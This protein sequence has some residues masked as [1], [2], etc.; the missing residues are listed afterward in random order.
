M[1]QSAQTS[2]NIIQ[3]GLAFGRDWSG[4]VVTPG[5]RS[6]PE[7]LPR[8]RFGLGGASVVRRHA[9]NYRTEDLN[10]KACEEAIKRSTDA[11]ARYQANV[12]DHWRA[13]K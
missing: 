13:G 7:I 1:I 5:S 11:C 10:G 4:T 3:K 2:N 9:A 8:R 12:P 6:A